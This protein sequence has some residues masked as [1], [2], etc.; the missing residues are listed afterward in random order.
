MTITEQ[1]LGK[2]LL[3]GYEHSFDLFEVTV[4]EIS[5]CGKFFKTVYPGGER[6]TDCNDAKYWQLRSILK[7]PAPSTKTE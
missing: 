6:W 5:P 7:S 2:R 1:D 4:T 3:V